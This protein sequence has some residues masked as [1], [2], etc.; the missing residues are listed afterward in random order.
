M[1]SLMIATVAAATIVPAE[2]VVAAPRV[3][4]RELRAVYNDRSLFPTGPRFSAKNIAQLTVSPEGRVTDCRIV[5][6]GGARFDEAL[7]DGST[8]LKFVPAKAAD[9]RAVSSPF[10]LRM[11]WSRPTAGSLSR[12][13]LTPT[14]P[15]PAP[16]RG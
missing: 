1:L 15:P 3:S 6:S 9:G 8:R 16:S 7:C 2:K 11:E 5:M 4:V 13:Q 10:I 14:L 12:P